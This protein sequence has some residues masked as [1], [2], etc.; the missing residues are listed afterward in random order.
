MIGLLV[1][2]AFSTFF[3][4]RTNYRISGLFSWD[5]VLGVSCCFVVFF[6]SPELC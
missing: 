2:R 4:C 1:F 5:V 6:F 3:F